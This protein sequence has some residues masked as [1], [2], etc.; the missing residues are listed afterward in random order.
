MHTRRAAV[1]RPSRRITNTTSFSMLRVIPR[2]GAHA[3]TSSVSSQRN[4]SWSRKNPATAST[5]FCPSLPL[6]STH[7]R[8]ARDL[9]HVEEEVGV[10]ALRG[11]RQTLEAP[12]VLRSGHR[13]RLDQNPL[14]VSAPR[15][16]NRDVATH[17]QKHALHPVRARAE[18]LLHRLQQRLLERRRDGQGVTHSHEIDVKRHDF[19][20]GLG[21]LENGTERGVVGGERHGR[22]VV[23]STEGEEL[24]RRRVVHY[25]LNEVMEEEGALGGLEGGAK[26]GSEVGGVVGGKGEERGEPGKQ[27]GGVGKTGLDVHN[28]GDTHEEQL[29]EYVRGEV[30]GEMGENAIDRI[31]RGSTMQNGY[32]S[33]LADSGNDII[34]ALHVSDKNDG[35]PI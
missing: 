25:D 30:M 14:K 33:L 17:N 12:I 24:K 1:A 4:C 31:R 19:V 22:R 11:R 29:H 10:G 9:C 18:K 20:G 2:R 6:H 28:I 3:F 16:C 34:Q 21:G 35:D 13:G 8:T 7:T 5:N 26:L 23:G 27:N 32:N 15:R